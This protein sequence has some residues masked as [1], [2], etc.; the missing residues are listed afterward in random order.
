[1]DDGDAR[2]LAIALHRIGA[3]KFGA[4]T[5]KDGRVSPFYIDLRG[6]VSHP[7]VL[8]LAARLVVKLTTPLAYDRLAGIP[9]A[10]LPLAVAM[11]LE[12]GRPMIY[13]R[14]EAAKSYGTK[15]RIEG[16]FAPGERALVIDDVITSG[17]AK[18]E[19]IE[20]LREAGLVVEDVAVVVQRDAWGVRRLNEAGLRLH[21]VLS[22]EAMF[23]YLRE[24]GVLDASH[25]VQALE[26]IHRAP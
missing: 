5:L 17:G 19:A 7:A 15:Q 25:Q 3:V 1:M 22:V 23:S 20:V 18:I 8:R 12:S 11:A 9:Y 26:F 21:A 16:E 2:D 24:H 10:G 13:A 14:K 6:L 4:F